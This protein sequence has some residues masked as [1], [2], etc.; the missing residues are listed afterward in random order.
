MYSSS[1]PITKGMGI[2]SGIISFNYMPATDVV[3]LAQ[4]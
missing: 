1:D 3:L 4:K 2:V